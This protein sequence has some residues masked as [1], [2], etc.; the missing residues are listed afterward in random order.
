MLYEDVSMIPRG[1]APPVQP[2]VPLCPCSY[3][4][5]HAALFGCTSETLLCQVCGTVSTWPL[6]S[7]RTGQV[8]HGAVTFCVVLRLD[9]HESEHRFD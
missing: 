7:L 5:M 1:A 4:R 3:Q 6:L 8:R 2:S 9:M